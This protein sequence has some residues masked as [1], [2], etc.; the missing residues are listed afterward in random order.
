MDKKVSKKTVTKSPAKKVNTVKKST[1]KKTTTKKVIKKPVNKVKAVIPKKIET[2]V[3]EKVIEEPKKKITKVDD[4]ERL[5]IYGALITILLVLSNTIINIPCEVFG[6]TIK[7]SAFVYPFTFLFSCIILKK[8][9]VME[10]IEALIVAIVVQLLMFFLRWI[11]VGNINV[12]L[13]VSAF[14]SFSVSQVACLCLY[15]ILLRNKLDTIFYAFLVFT[16][17]ILFDNG[18]FLSLLKNFGDNTVGL[19]ALN[20]SNIIKVLFSF[21]IAYFITEKEW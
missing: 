7:L 18:I 9:G 5:Y 13:F 15:G 1:P 11:I 14:V 8:Y 2:K 21:L 3:E 16:I 19:N 6:V 10:V 12:G 4:S 20:V 17:C